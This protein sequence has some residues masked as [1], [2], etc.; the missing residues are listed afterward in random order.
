MPK[1]ALA[2]E[3]VTCCTI[4]SLR[5]PPFPLPPTKWVSL[6]R[7]STPWCTRQVVSSGA[8]TGGLRRKGSLYCHLACALWT[9]ELT[10]REPHAMCGVQLGAL[11]RHRLELQC[12]LC[13][14][15]GGAVM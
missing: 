6:S 10:L 11:T 2:S 8:L 12:E 9:P 13:K 1:H 5:S 14:Q 7:S 3:S 4:C 15:A